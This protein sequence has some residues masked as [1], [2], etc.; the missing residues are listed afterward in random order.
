M[1]RKISTL[2]LA[3][4]VALA[5]IFRVI[6][7]NW[8]NGAHL[9]PDE[10]FLTMVGI[11]MK[12]P[13]S[14]A[15]YMDPLS[16]PFNPATIGYT[17]FVYGLLPLSLNKILALFAGTD[18]YLLYTLQGRIFSAAMDVLAVILIYKIGEII[19]THYRLH[20]KSLKLWA[21][22][23]YATSVLAI[24][25]SHF[26]AVDSFLNTFSLASAF[27]LMKTAVELHKKERTL[28]LVFSYAA[29]S[30]ILWGAALSSKVTA[31]FMIPLFLGMIA[32]INGKDIMRRHALLSAAL[33]IGLAYLTVRIANP[34]M[35][36]SGNIFDIRLSSLYL[37]NLQELK[38]YEDPTSFFPPMVQ[39]THTT[40]LIYSFTNLF[41]YSYGPVATILTVIGGIVAFKKKTYVLWVIAIYSLVFFIYQATRVTQPVRYFN[42]ILPYFAILAAVGITYLGTITKRL[43]L[44]LIPLILVWPVAF[45]SIYVNPHSRIS[46]SRWMYQQIPEGSVIA[47]EHWDDA[48]PISVDPGV[49]KQYTF[50]E[51]PV[52][53]PD[54]DPNKWNDLYDKLGKAD[55][56]VLSS[57]RA[58]RSIMNAPDKYPQMSIF[59]RD[60]FSGRNKDFRFRAKFASYPSLRYL[61][62]P[63]DFPTTHADETFTVYDHPEVYIFK[64]VTN[65]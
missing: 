16:S 58:W 13:M 38:G 52:F 3:I 26:F 25:L 15:Q 50:L 61:G 49:V 8:D 59:Y 65:K 62:I 14:W 43:H 54:S 4:I 51:L 55:Y 36:E 30:G 18:T 9:H 5:A 45:M 40:P 10:R 39:W 48:L 57:N 53:A 47:V 27:F 42:I 56:Y 24:Q 32:V 31:V 63:I 17:F 29:M 28:V 60:L 37:K 19:E 34:Y 22:F 2:L 33:W 46:A 44:L 41:L 7:F 23:V 20:N 6:G 35:F 21:A 1:S 64:R 12:L 11:A